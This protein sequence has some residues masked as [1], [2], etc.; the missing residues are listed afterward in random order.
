MIRLLDPTFWFYII[1]ATVWAYRAKRSLQS[2]QRIPTLT[3]VISGNSGSNDLVTIVLPA[4]NEEKNI[5]SCIQRFLAQDY[6]NL[7]ILIV[8]DR[9]IDRTESILQDLHIPRLS[10]VPGSHTGKTIPKLG[11]INAQPTPEGWT[12]KNFAI[13]SGLEYARGQW[14]VFTDAD[15]RHEP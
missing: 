5:R 3:P 9:S 13:H 2:R 1:I 14:L 6:P 7:Q 11:Y 12:G 15:T 10:Q 4:K 8:N